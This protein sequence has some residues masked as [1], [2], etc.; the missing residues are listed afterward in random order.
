[1]ERI[2][3]ISQQAVLPMT[4]A[5]LQVTVPLTLLSFSAG[6]ILAA[7][8][9]LARISNR[10]ILKQTAA[11]YVWLFRGT[12]LL[13]QLFVCFFGLPSVGIQLDV[14]SAA[15]ITFSLNTGAYASESI[16]SAI[17]AVPK[18]QFEAATSLGMN[19]WQVMRW[20]IAPQALKIALPPLSN[21][22][23]SL[24]KD[25]SLAASITLVDVFMTAQR[26]AAR[27][28]EPLLLYSL[29]AAYYL[30]VCTA[31]NYLQTHLEK[32]LTVY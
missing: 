22:F 15:L 6:F 13:V 28:Y 16:R 10:L 20:I 18:G 21:N 14:W 26:I 5:L 11:A 2:W 27:T 19:R 29:A 12:P 32:K 8:A 4:K 25:T 24:V 31:L 17:L 7:W 1:M 23:I 3:V 30:I 9:A